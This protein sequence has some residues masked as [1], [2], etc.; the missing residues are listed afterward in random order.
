MSLVPSEANISPTKIRGR[1]HPGSPGAVWILTFSSINAGDVYN[2]PWT[3]VLVLSGWDM[4]LLWHHRSSYG[5]RWNCWKSFLFAIFSLRTETIFRWRN[6]GK[7]Y[8]WTPAFTDFFLNGKGSVITVSVHSA[9][10]SS[11]HASSELVGPPRYLFKLSQRIFLISDGLKDSSQIMLT[12]FLK[13]SLVFWRPPFQYHSPSRKAVL[14][15]YG[16]NRGSSSDFGDSKISITC[17]S[18]SG[19][20]EGTLER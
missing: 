13:P 19:S 7:V 1:G 9:S 16:R 2:S 8:S 3:L 14:F 11:N 12:R 6:G 15:G 4:S 5:S 18:E 10:G 20:C 17:A